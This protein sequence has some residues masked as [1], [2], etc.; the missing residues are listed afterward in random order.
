MSQDKLIKCQMCGE[1]IP[2]QFNTEYEQEE[3]CESCV[4][5]L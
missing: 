1:E 2:H 3:I 5:E 4:N